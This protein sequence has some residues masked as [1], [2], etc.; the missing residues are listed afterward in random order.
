MVQFLS[1]NF[2]LGFLQFLSGFSEV[3]VFLC[4]PVERD[5]DRRLEGG[6]PYYN[7]AIRTASAV[8]DIFPECRETE[9]SKISRS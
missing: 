3:P 7:N 5:R 1:I 8:D 9:A 2:F 6:G 4:H